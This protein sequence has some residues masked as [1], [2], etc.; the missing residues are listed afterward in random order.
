M[1]EVK[2]SFK[3]MLTNS[4]RFRLRLEL[5]LLAAHDG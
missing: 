5:V 3:R 1:V 2:L 4:I